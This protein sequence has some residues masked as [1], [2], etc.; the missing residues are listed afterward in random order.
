MR[1]SY[2]HTLATRKT[3]KSAV[4]IRPSGTEVLCQNW[5]TCWT[6]LSVSGISNK[7]RT[8]KV[9]AISKAQKT[10]NI[11]FFFGK[12]RTVPKNVEG[13]LFLIYKH[14]FYCKITKN[15]KGDPLG[16]LKNFRKK[17]AQCQKN[18]NGD[19][20]VPS[21]FVGYLEIVKNERGD[22]LH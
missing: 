5:R 11:F 8:S 14:A 17:V 22:P 7:T 6:I 20:L 2:P 13:G 3:R 12:C 10:Q 9:G 4:T 18:Q 15:S 16:T 1:G 19:P 21:G